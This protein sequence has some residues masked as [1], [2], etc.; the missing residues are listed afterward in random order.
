MLDRL[1]S[2]SDMQHHPE[3]LYDAINPSELGAIIAEHRNLL[4]CSL[5]RPMLNTFEQEGI[6]LSA[7]LRALATLS[8][9]RSST[10]S[11][12]DSSNPWLQCEA[13]LHEARAMAL[14]AEQRPKVTR[15]DREENRPAALDYLA[16][17]GR[18]PETPLASPTAP[19][20]SQQ[21]NKNDSQ[22][23]QDH[24]SNQNN[25]N[26][27]IAP[28]VAPASNGSLREGTIE[29]DINSLTNGLDLSKLEADLS[30]NLDWAKANGNSS[31]TQNGQ[32][33]IGSVTPIPESSDSVDWSQVS[34]D[35]AWAKELLEEN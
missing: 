27:A 32:T 26:G 34:E 35:D 17:A 18:S 20:T 30:A 2:V 15:V 24:Q 6:Q 7:I 33:E 1:D 4:L 11:A 31:Q 9:E 13:L 10:L 21:H 23:H 16:K 3:R 8:Q 19:E 22:N 28:P 12:A 14:L 29:V 5:L 25:Q